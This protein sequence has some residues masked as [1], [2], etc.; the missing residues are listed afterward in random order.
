MCTG[1]ALAARSIR[2]FGGKSSSARRQTYF[3]ILAD[4]ALHIFIQFSISLSWLVKRWP[5]FSKGF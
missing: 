3:D 1:F 5:I 4:T 2:R